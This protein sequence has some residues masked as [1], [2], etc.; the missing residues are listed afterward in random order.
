[1]AVLL[2]GVLSACAGEPSASAP[3]RPGG[4]SA[5][6]RHISAVPRVQIPVRVGPEWTPVATVA[7]NV[8]GWIAQQNGATLL[9]F[10]QRF[11][12]LDLHAGSQ[13][14]G[15]AGWTYGARMASSERRHVL[16]AFNGGFELNSVNVGFAEDGRTP[17]TLKLGLAS[18]VTD[19]SGTTAIEAW[20]S[21][22]HPPSSVFSVLQNLRLLVDGGG[23]SPT[24]DSCVQQC[25][26]ATLGGGTSVPR[27]A[28]GV[29]ANG[30]LVFAAGNLTPGGIGRALAGVG[31]QRAV[32]LDINPEW[33]AAYLYVHH[34]SGPVA[35]PAV[36]GQS[37]LPGHLLLPYSRDFFTVVSR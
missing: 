10:D 37:G 8:A 33:V 18:I 9:R 11:V 27:S 35:V 29:T 6:L 34:G 31:V 16:A 15:G 5:G 7:G 22:P 1:M 2:A 23:V 32:E 14:P 24:A 13:D 19:R 3:N 26:G 17:V 36:P 20:P 25:W 30:Q 28:L 12:R 21:G 4:V